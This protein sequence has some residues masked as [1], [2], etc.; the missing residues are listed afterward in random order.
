MTTR[1]PDSRPLRGITEET[2]LSHIRNHS[3]RE[4]V[5]QYM[6]LSEVDGSEQW[7]ISIRLGDSRNRLTPIR[8][9]R[10]P[11]RYWKSLKAVASFCRKRGVPVAT[12]EW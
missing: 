4:V 8:S 5:V 10:E 9:K 7:T 11:V 1:D 12:V 6:G 3:A 2:F